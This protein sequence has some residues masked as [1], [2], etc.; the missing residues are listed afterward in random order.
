MG[1]YAIV[2]VLCSAVC[3]AT[4]NVLAKTGGDPVR[5]V[6]TALKYSTI[7]YAP[8]FVA[9]T[10][11]ARYSWYYFAC[12]TSSGV[13][14]GLYFYSLSRA[15]RAG[16]VSVAYPI[17]RSFPIL[18]VT[19]ASMVWG[20]WPSARGLTGIV[21]VVIGSFVLPARRFARGPDGFS[22]SNYLNASCAWAVLTAL[23]TAA[24]SLIDK[25][26]AVHIP[27]EPRLVSLA[28]RVNYVYLQDVIAWLTILVVTR[29]GTGAEEE[30]KRGQAFIAGALFLISYSLII[31]AFETDHVAYVVSFRQISIVIA[32][33]IAMIRVEKNAPLPRILGVLLIFAGVVMVGI[34]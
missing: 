12:V 11:Y 22:L 15:Y 21:L 20:D 29:K 13:C 6:R 10:F 26:V 7:L 3:H 24:F 8:L 14:T 32:A 1:T 33:V 16:H 18:V 25:S 19:W 4:W 34:G 31:L 30:H 28:S 23:A 2:L 17:A 9:L 5:V 27:G